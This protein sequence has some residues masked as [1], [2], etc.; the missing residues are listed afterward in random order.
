MLMILWYPDQQWVSMLGF[1]ILVDLSSLGR[2]R[3]FDKDYLS[4]YMCMYMPVV[5]SSGSSIW[6]LYPRESYDSWEDLKGS[7]KKIFDSTMWYLVRILYPRESYDFWADPKGPIRMVCQSTKNV[8]VDTPA[9]FC[10][11]MLMMMLFQPRVF[12]VVVPTSCC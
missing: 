3:R 7:V 12:D 9:S 5:V 10:F 4:E 8:V 6:I 1:Y 11:H 2:S